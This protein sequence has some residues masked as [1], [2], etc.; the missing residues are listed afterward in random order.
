MCISSFELRCR[1]EHDFGRAARGERWAASATTSPAESGTL[2]GVST[3]PPPASG[4]EDGFSGWADSGAT[5]HLPTS[6][7]LLVAAAGRAP[8]AQTAG[9]PEGAGGGGSDGAAGGS[10]GAGGGGSEIVACGGSDGGGFPRTDCGTLIGMLRLLA[11][12]PSLIGRK[13]TCVVGCAGGA[14][15]FDLE[16]DRGKD[17]RTR[18]LRTEGG[19][20]TFISR[21][22]GTP[23]PRCESHDRSGSR[24]HGTAFG[25]GSALGMGMFLDF[26]R[27]ST[28]VL[29][30]ST[31]AALLRRDAPPKLGKEGTGPSPARAPEALPA[32]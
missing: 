26:R 25:W 12:P 27:C 14:G 2:I 21:S 11:L 32:A 31:L 17:L 24:S 9:A 3:V 8:A 4:T 19:R 15:S 20:S 1:E 6:G 10:E 18:L 5:E 13:S 29:N 30:E 23:L 22:P 28:Q 16:G 7:G